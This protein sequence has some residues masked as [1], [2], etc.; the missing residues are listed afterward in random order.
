MSKSINLEIAYA[1]TF[2]HMLVSNIGIFLN[3]EIKS[4]GNKDGLY[5]FVV[6]EKQDNDTCISNRKCHMTLGDAIRDRDERL[7]K[8]RK[9][10]EQG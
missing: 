6:F 7:E 1:A 8:R 3:V 5:P 4:N 2:D 10:L 9:E